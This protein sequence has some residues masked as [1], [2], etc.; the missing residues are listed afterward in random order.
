MRCD[1]DMLREQFEAVTLFMRVDL[2]HCCGSLRRFLKVA[3]MGAQPWKLEGTRRFPSTVGMGCTETCASMGEVSVGTMPQAG[4]SDDANP[5]TCEC[6]IDRSLS[7][8]SALRVLQSERCSEYLDAL[9]KALISAHPLTAS[10]DASHQSSH[11]SPPPP[12]PWPPPPPLHEALQPP[13]L[14]LPALTELEADTAAAAADANGDTNAAATEA[15]N[16]GTHD[17]AEAHA[18][19]EA[20]LDDI[21]GRELATQVRQFLDDRGLSH[22]VLPRLNEQGWV[23]LGVGDREQRAALLRFFRRNHD[24]NPGAT[25]PITKGEVSR[26]HALTDRMIETGHRAAGDEERKALETKRDAAFSEARTQQ[27]YRLL[28]SEKY[29]ATLELESVA[30][31]RALEAG[32]SADKGAKAAGLTGGEEGQVVAAALISTGEGHVTT[33]KGEAWQ[34]GADSI[35]EKARVCGLSAYHTDILAC[36]C[37]RAR[38]RACVRVCVCECVRACVCARAR[39]CVCACVH[40]CV[41]YS[42]RALRH[43]DLEPGSEWQLAVAEQSH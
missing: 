13:P 32:L 31:F 7:V 25:V 41:P 1:I 15:A 22:E 5:G 34:L 29:N 36:V 17:S 3:Q 28:Q 14:P 10:A 2:T 16:Q 23:D 27:R 6:D 33:G 35:R 30:R 12:P 26:L 19:V 43:P 24:S 11:P 37:A 42:R 18:M 39:A 4:A 9:N 38:V 21:V 20:Q 40:A 8:A